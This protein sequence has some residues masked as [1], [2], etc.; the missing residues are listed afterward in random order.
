MK[1]LPLAS[2]IM[3]LQACRVT[4]KKAPSR[5]NPP[6]L[7]WTA[8]A[9]RERDAPFQRQL[10]VPEPAVRPILEAVASAQVETYAAPTAANTQLIQTRHPPFTNSHT[11]L[12]VAGSQLPFSSRDRAPTKLSIDGPDRPSP[13]KITPNPRAP[14][15]PPTIS[16]LP[17]T[18]HLFADVRC[19]R[20]ER[21]PTNPLSKP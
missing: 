8:V 6:L 9:V 4:K 14:A 5:P 10:S 2:V 1:Q 19:A 18:T 21:Q 16:A 17:S 13:E 15:S 7:P 3:H 12:A 11:S 20:D